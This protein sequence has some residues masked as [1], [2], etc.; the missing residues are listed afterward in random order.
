MRRTTARI[1]DAKPSLAV[2]ICLA[3]VA[4]ACGRDGAQPAP[5]SIPSPVA[6]VDTTPAP[7]PAPPSAARINV[8]EEV[9]DALTSHGTSRLFEVTAPSEGTLVVQVSWNASQGLLALSLQDAPFTGPFWDTD[10]RSDAPGH[11]IAKVHV[12]A[13]R[14]FRVKIADG[15][16]WDYDDLNVQFVLAVSME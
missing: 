7:S 11:V 3:L 16:P 2:L 15:A 10:V 13:G 5:S 8:G 12:V 9:K 4:T 1:E 6:P 14:T